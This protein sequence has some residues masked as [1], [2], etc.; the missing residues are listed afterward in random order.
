[1]TKEE[2]I[3]ML[4]NDAEYTQDEIDCMSNFELFD[5]WCVWQGIYGGSLELWQT[6]IELS[7]DNITVALNN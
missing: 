4:I 6:V 5:A 7:D 2:I 1:M 3:D